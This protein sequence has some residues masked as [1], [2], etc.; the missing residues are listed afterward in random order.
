M[1]FGNARGYKPQN[2]DSQCNLGNRSSGPTPCA[3]IN[4]QQKLG[5]QPVSS[6]YAYPSMHGQHALGTELQDALRSAKLLHSCNSSMNA[7]M[8]PEGHQAPGMLSNSNLETHKVSRY[9]ML[10]ASKHHTPGLNRYESN[11]M[12][13]GPPHPQN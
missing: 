1:G 10:H 2:A 5:T 8:A 4:N 13:C 11:R 12:H 3:Y 6:L 9:L 7:T